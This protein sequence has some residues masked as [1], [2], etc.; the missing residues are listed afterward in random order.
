MELID[1]RFVIVGSPRPVVKFEEEGMIWCAQEQ[2][3]TN[4]NQTKRQK[5]KTGNT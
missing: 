5:N 2:E 1:P 3:K 4:K